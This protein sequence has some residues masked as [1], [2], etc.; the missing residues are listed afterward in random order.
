LTVSIASQR[1]QQ[2]GLAERRKCLR[3]DLVTGLIAAEQE[4]EVLRDSELLDVCGLLFVAGGFIAKF[5][6]HGAEAQLSCEGEGKVRQ[7]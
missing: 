3:S 7:R 4:G 1:F 5:A 2:T 6:A